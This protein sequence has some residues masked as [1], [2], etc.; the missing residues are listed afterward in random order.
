MKGSNQVKQ[1]K[2]NKAF[3]SLAKLRDISLPIKKARAIYKMYVMME[4]AYNFAANEEKKYLEEF[5]GVLD[6]DGSISFKTH[7]DCLAFKERLD[8]LCD[9]EVEL[10]LEAITLLEG[11]L[12]DQMLTPG[13]IYN[14]EGFVIFE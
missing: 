13:D 12:G 14:L 6:D 1:E 8:E 9:S 10:D 3:P 11:D 4:E 7:E 2:I 5:G